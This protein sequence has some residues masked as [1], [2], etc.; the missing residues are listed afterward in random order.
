MHLV[1][2]LA[3]G[4]MENGLINLINHMPPNRYRHVIACL[5]DYTDFRH[6]IKCATDVPVLALHQADGHDSRV[7]GR[8]WG[9]MRD[10]RPA[11]VHTRNLPSLEHVIP[12][13]LAGVPARIHGEHGRDMHD[14]DGVNRKYN[15]LRKALRPLIHHYIA[16]STDLAGWL[17]GTVGIRP[18]R[19]TQVYNGVD[20]ERFHPRTGPRRP[21]GP[22]GFAP[23]GT[24]IVGTV[25]RLEPVK[26]QLT[27]V[28][29]FLHL[30]DSEPDRGER[31]RLAMIGDGLL[32]EESRQLLRGVGAERLAWLPG[33]RDDVSEILPALDLFVLPSLREGISNTILEAMASGL[34][35]V[36][37]RVGGNPELV[38]HERTGMLVPP[39]DPVA[40][41]EAIRFYLQHPNEVRRHGDAARKKVESQ[42]SMEAMVNGYMAVYDRVLGE[43][44]QRRVDR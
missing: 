36:A 8:L 11:I 17:I 9:L 6:R 23:A 27:L 42:F 7:H 31:L 25:G 13:A 34:P 10:L 28:R 22:E 44:R 32:L 18:D 15:L 37:T 16:V 4:G 3:V 40:L 35:V 2:R 30:L 24:V 19:V 33:T 12:A 21:L 43:R 41:A 39:S 29:A 26:D 38:D 1:R 14:L 20:F 5:T